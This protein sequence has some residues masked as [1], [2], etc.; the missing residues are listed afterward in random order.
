ML[1]CL[2]NSI[3]K[4]N[5]NDLA[6]KFQTNTETLKIVPFS[7]SFIFFFGSKLVTRIFD[8]H[9]DCLTLFLNTDQTVVKV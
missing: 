4:P 3:S 9:S 8:A 2:L 1:V 5:P 6:L 7:F